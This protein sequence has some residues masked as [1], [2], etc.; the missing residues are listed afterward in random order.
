MPAQPKATLEELLRLL[1]FNATVVEHE[2]EGNLLLDVQCDDSGRL[3]GRKGQTL[4]ALQYVLNRLLYQQAPDAPKVTI[5]VAGYRGQAREELIK[6]AK[7]A[8]E[9]VRRWGDVVELE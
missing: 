6:K 7:A 3:I 5:D 2:W 8:A 1:G 9:K 4:I